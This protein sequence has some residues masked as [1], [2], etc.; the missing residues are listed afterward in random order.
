MSGDARGG[1]T[2]ASGSGGGSG[3]VNGAE[4]NGGWQ[5]SVLREASG[6]APGGSPRQQLLV[7]GGPSRS[8]AK[9]WTNFEIDDAGKR[10]TE[11]PAAGR[12]RCAGRG[13]RSCQWSL[14]WG[15]C[16]WGTEPSGLP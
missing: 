4:Y 13:R 5:S 7:G 1:N 2:S 12:R 16:G 11:A 6:D 10:R 8:G 14:W 15:G 9:A 3:R